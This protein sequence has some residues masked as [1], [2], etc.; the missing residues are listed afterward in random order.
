M[1][2]LASGLWAIAAALTLRCAMEAE[3][4]AVLPSSL[5]WTYR[6]LVCG[7]FAVAVGL[8]ARA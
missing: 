7:C 3:V 6:V 4:R 5:W 2:L 1:T 8:L